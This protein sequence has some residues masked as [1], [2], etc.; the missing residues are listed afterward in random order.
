MKKIVVFVMLCSLLAGLSSCVTDNQHAGSESS[1]TQY[2]LE[3]AY[4]EGYGQATIEW[5]YKYDEDIQ[6]KIYNAADCAAWQVY[7]EYDDNMFCELD[8]APFDMYEAI[9]TLEDYAA[10]KNVSPQ[11]VKAAI[12][13]VSDFFYKTEEYMENLRK[14]PDQLECWHDEWHNYCKEEEKT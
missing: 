1:L 9:Y 3:E 6:Q 4:Y 14:N 8:E 2:D 11:K 13:R 7:M 10:G 12:L 5:E